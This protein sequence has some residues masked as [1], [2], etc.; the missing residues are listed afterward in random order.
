MSMA[1]QV[2]EKAAPIGR[3]TALRPVCTSLRREL[4]T[5]CLALHVYRG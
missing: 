2:G 4:E 1:S 3:A 5:S